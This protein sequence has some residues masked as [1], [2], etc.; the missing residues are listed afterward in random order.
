MGSIVKKVKRC[1]VP[2][3]FGELTVD[4]NVRRVQY[5]LSFRQIM[6]VATA[7]ML[8]MTAFLL[9]EGPPKPPLRLLVII[10]LGWAWLVGGNLAYGLPH[11]A[12]FLRRA[13]ETAPRLK[14]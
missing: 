11:F 4:G 8:F 7:L 9:F 12:S 6:L 3:G 13:I 1:L 2:F 10:P 14:R 5:R